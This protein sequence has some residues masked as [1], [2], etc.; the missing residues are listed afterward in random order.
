MNACETMGK[1]SFADSLRWGWGKKEDERHGEVGIGL[2]GKKIPEIVTSSDKKQYI[3][4][5]LFDVSQNI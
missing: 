4:H 3:V 1:F 2:G 5:I